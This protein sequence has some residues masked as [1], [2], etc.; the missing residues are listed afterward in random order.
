MSRSPPPDLYDLAPRVDSGG[1]LLMDLITL[2]FETYYAQDYSLD[3]LTT[4]AYVRDPRF[5]MILVAIKF[6]NSPAF[7]LMR[8]RFEHFIRE[9]VDWSQTAVIAHH[10]HFDGLILSHHFGVRPAMWIDTL[11]MARVIDGPKARNGLEFLAP[12]YGLGEKGRAVHWAKGKRLDDFSGSEI[13]YYGD[14]CCNDANLTYKLA[15]IFLPQIPESEVKLIDLT[16]R[17]F[18]EPVLIGNEPM[19]AGAVESERQR[20]ID[21]L[22]RVNLLCQVCGGSGDDPVKDLVEG[23]LPCKKCDGQGVDKKP[24]GSSEQFANLLRGFGVEPEMKQGKNEMIYAFAK[25]DPAMQA[26][27]EHEDEDVRFLAEA[28]IGIKS[29]LVLTRAQRYHDCAARGPMPVYIKYGAA[30]TLRMGGGDSMNWQNLS[31][32]NAKRPEMSVLNASIQAP[33]GHKLVRCDSGQGEARLVAW[34]AGQWDLVQAFANGEDVYSGFAS[35]VYGRPIDRKR[36]AEDHIPGQVGKV[37]ILG[38]GF[39]MGWYKFSMELL[40]GMLGNPPIQFTIADMEAMHIDPSR[41]LGNPK[42]IQRVNEMPSRLALSDRLIHC[43]VAQSLNQ[44]Y[45]KRYAEIPRYWDLMESVITA[46]I[47]GEEMVFAN[48]ILRTGHECIHLPGGMQLNYR[49]LARSNDGSAS[50]WDG[51]KRTHIYGG[52]LTENVTQCLH[53]LIVC[54]Q[55]LEISRVLKVALMRHDDVVCVVPDSAAE[56]AKQYMVQ[57][58]SKTPD[59]I[60]GLPL[61]GEGAIGR[62]LL[63]AK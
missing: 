1:T 24:I 29:N 26:L 49:G 9:E 44:Q 23:T 48:G 45:R 32:V 63:E 22:Y 37:S 59:W 42:N 58:M 47:R 33:P 2:D 20:K 19:L 25:T 6:D 18:T 34:Q 27:L 7:W 17:M 15:Q 43:A 11:S 12:R 36:V 35:V 16:T 52:L 31:G 39:G 62:T 40:K 57:V 51:R 60:P 21:L 13:R 38:K 8:D 5:E 28:R 54:E 10:T 30:H 53:R 14:Y 4:E 46:M 56:E 55:M 3:L 61:V 41:F 50:Y